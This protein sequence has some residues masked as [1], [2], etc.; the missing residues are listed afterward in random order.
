M[1]H[2]DGVS[3]GI[4]N[5]PTGTSKLSSSIPGPSICGNTNGR[6]GL[7][8]LW[9]TPSA[10]SRTMRQSSDTFCMQTTNVEAKAHLDHSFRYDHFRATDDGRVCCSLTNSRMSKGRTALFGKKLFTASCSFT[11]TSKSVSS[12]S[13]KARPIRVPPT[14]RSLSAPP[15]LRSRA[16]QRTRALSP[17]SS[18]SFV[19]VKFRM[20]FAAPD[21]ESHIRVVHFVDQ[22]L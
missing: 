17:S 6:F 18:K 11:K 16:L 19:S 1:A 13:F 14:F 9:K 3:F 4:P 20:I 22:T 8:V 12:L 21:L 2:R 7:I 5:R 15:D 10:V